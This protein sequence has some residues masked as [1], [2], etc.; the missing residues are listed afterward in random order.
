LLKFL[1]PYGFVA[2][3]GGQTPI[4]MAPAIADQGFKLL[5]SSLEAIDLAE[6]RGRFVEVCRKAGFKVPRSG[7]ASAEGMALKIAEEIGYPVICRPSYVLGGRRM[8]LIENS[9][10]M[11]SYFSRHGAFISQDTPC[12]M[13]Q[14]LDRAL[15]VDVD[16]VR[17]VDWQVVGGIIEHIEAAGVHSGDSMGV[18]PPQRLKDEVCLKIEEMSQLLADK[19]GILGFLNLQ[20][21][22]KDDEIFM[23]EA[24]PRSSRSVPFI[25]KATGVPLVDL[26]VRAMIGE[27]N[28]T[29]ESK[30]YDWH[31]ISKVSVKGVVFPF[32]KF[33]ESDSILGPEMKSTGE[34]M[35]R[36]S[37]YSEA[38]LKAMFSSQV[39]MPLSGEVF[40]SLRDKDKEE[41]LPVAK[42]LLEMGFTLS[43]TGGTAAFLSQRGLPVTKINKV[44]EGRPHCVDRIR[45][46]LVSIVIN[47]TSGRQSIEASFGIRRSCVDYSIPCITESDAAV[48]FLLALQKHHSG[49][50]K[51]FSL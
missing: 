37:D 38:L 6:D 13:D 22:I 10:E 48:A 12:L 32:K 47:T 42:G 28:E 30:N 5:G 7:M 27:T 31:R 29:V 20:L 26:G 36:G 15:E 8:E 40:F 17:G 39:K 9:E 45:S 3:L 19:L 14:F 41:L 25:A 46:G 43:A 35:G 1:N 18:V 4:N 51:V 44:H 24:N 50:F 49:D 21:A 34:S 16:L 11:Q 33:T 2:Q 23:L